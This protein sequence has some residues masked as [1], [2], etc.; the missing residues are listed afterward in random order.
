MSNSKST[1][2]ASPTWPQW[3]GFVQFRV[4]PGDTAA[5]L[6]AVRAGV[7]RLERTGPG[8]VVLPELWAG[9]FD[10]PTL[11]RQA[12]E[13]G[14]LLTALTAIAGDY[15]IHLAG[16]LPEEVIDSGE[17]RTF[18]KGVAFETGGISGFGNSGSH[19]TPP[20]RGYY[21]TLYLVG[22]H[23]VVGSYRKQ[24]LFSP[25]GE[26]EYFCPAPAAPRPLQAPWGPVAALV[27]FDLRFP[28]LATA[29]V[30]AGADIL[31]VSAQ[32]PEAR[33]EHWQVLLRA[34]A[35]E[36]QVFVVAANTCGRI[37]ERDF[38][39]HSQV[40]APDGQLMIQAGA[41][42]AS[43]AVDLEWTLLTNTR[44]L[45]RTVPQVR[46]SSRSSQDGVLLDSYF[47]P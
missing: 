32:W 20:P 30:A 23:G 47:F 17:C 2:V 10:Y 15:G 44:S 34:R 37:G 11:A 6:E 8:L 28:A 13:S 39:G 38:A 7:G 45:F 24:R 29:Q 21:N 42:E 36:N 1:K 12:G 9:G 31:L 22:P 46:K 35:I 18:G 25:M 41:E 43:A 27:C 40:I 26:E 14:E 33:R 3:A 16:S 5:N 19:V 4:R